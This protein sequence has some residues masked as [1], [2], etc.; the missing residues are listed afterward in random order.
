MLMNQRTAF[1][2]VVDE[3][4]VSLHRYDLETGKVLVREELE[5]STLLPLGGQVEQKAPFA[6]DPE[7]LVDGKLLVVDGS[8]DERGH[9][10]FSVGRVFCC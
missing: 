9:I 2:C 1:R 6:R 7:E 8:A 5:H 4:M 3:S 10:L